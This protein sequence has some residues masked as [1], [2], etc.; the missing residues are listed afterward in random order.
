[1]PEGFKPRDNVE[2]L[3]RVYV[4][5]AKVPMAATDAWLMCVR[6]CERVCARVCVRVAALGAPS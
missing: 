6:A 3:E 4:Q 2:T 1:M 5:A